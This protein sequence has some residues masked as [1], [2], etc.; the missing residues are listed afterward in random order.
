MEPESQ[1]AACVILPSDILKVQTQEQWDRE[2][3]QIGRKKLQD[4]RDTRGPRHRG[5]PEGEHEE[6][7][8]GCTNQFAF[9]EQLIALISSERTQPRIKARILPLR[10]T[11]PCPT[12]QK[13]KHSSVFQLSYTHGGSIP[14]LWPL[15][16]SRDQT[17][18]LALAYRPFAESHSYQVQC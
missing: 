17:C 12:S 5:V 4:G 2:V 8:M 7:R 3:A 11:C 18:K 15:F 16:A 13:S 1:D 14:M 6:K 9:S 10:L